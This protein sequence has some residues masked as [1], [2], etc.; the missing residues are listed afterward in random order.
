MQFTKGLT[1]SLKL[2][3]NI[4]QDN[5][6]NAGGGSGGSSGGGLLTPS[7]AGGGS[8][9]PQ[10][11]TGTPNSAT[12]GQ[13]TPGNTDSNQSPQQGSPQ[14]WRLGLPT[15]LQEDATLRKFSDIPSLAAAYI[16]AQKLIGAEK[17]AIPGKHA[18]D[19][20]WMG[21]YKKLGLPEKVE[22]YD[23]KIN[24]SATLDENFVKSFKENA[25]K[26]GIL[27]GQAQKLA[28]WFSEINM[29]SEG[30]YMEET[31]AKQQQE[32]DGLKAEWGKNFD[33]NLSR[34]KLVLKN[35]ADKDTLQYMEDTG[36]TNDVRLA[37][38]FSNLGSKLYKETQIV[39]GDTPSAGAVSPQEAKKSIDSIMGN[40]N[41]PY[42]IKDHP[43]HKAAVAEVQGL[44]SIMYNE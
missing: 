15:E 23:I 5:N 43:G 11:G 19:E 13:A 27:P 21:V 41:H 36:L 6:P 39:G 2:W 42:F 26:F 33:A 17:I 37:K 25:H 3:T 31:K 9:D 40:K 16:N 18:S 28:D 7:N 4:L 1:V 12:G 30:K 22:E 10:G 35:F 14:D 38:L 44:F 20:D 32:I 24:E 34:A 8:G 29:A